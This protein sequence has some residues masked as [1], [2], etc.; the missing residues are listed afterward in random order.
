MASGPDPGGRSRFA[1]L[2]MA[3][4]EELNQACRDVLEMEVPPG[5]IYNKVKASSIYK[6]IRPE[7][8]LRL[9]GAKTD[10]YKEFDITLLYTLIRNISTKIPPPTKGW[11][12]N[13][14][15]PVGETTIGDD[16]ERIRMIRNS[17]FGHISSASTSQTEFDD[18]WQIITDVCQRLQTY[19]NKDYLSG[20]SNIQSQALEE[21]NEK[22]IIENL[23]A[24]YKNNTDLME[25]MSCL[26]SYLL[27]I[28]MI[29]E[30]LKVWQKENVAFIP[31]KA[32]R[33]VEEKLKSHNLVIVVGNSG[34]GKSAIIQHI[35][36]KY[37]D[38][39]SYVVP[40]DEVKEIK[41]KYSYSTENQTLFVLNDPLGKESLDEILFTLWKKYQKTIE[42]CLKKVKLLL[43]CRR[44]VLYDKRIK[45]ILFEESTIV[46][47]DNK[48]NGLTG[49]EKRAILNQYTQNLD[50][51]EEIVF[52]IIKTEAYFPLLCKL[53][54][55]PNYT[56]NGLDFFKF[57]KKFIKQ[58][59]D[60]FK[61][62]D[63][64]KFCTLILVVAF[65]NNLKIETIERN[66][67]SKKKYKDIL[68]MCE[69]SESTRISA[70]RS[71]L[72]EL[73]GSYVKCVGQTFQFLHDFIMEITTLVFGAECPKETI[74]YADSGFLRRRV[75]IV[76][77]TEEEN[78]D[79]FTVYLPEEYIGDLV[80]R[81]IVDMQ[82]E[83]IVDV[84]FNPC[85]RNKTGNDEEHLREA[86][87]ETKEGERRK[88]VSCLLN[89]GA[90]VNLCGDDGKPPLWIT[91]QKGYASTLVIMDMIARYNYY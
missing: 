2:G 54:S 26:E 24:H 52:E 17:M 32:S 25:R 57:P 65:K 18:T 1:K 67:E 74:Q 76:D 41:E 77:D 44:C 7:Q 68:E 47:I 49:V 10:G 14:M 85:L 61:R 55:R 23:E 62:I 60:I 72:Q 71:T 88:T 6:N 31:T 79:P 82:T 33:I 3:I 83:H 75:R 87:K 28:P 34:S 4:N 84:L 35:A 19:T 51:S 40:V 5:L 80:D 63:K 30:I 39:G 56:E 48:E 13:T 21:E 22:A 70:F 11:G 66:D 15:P 43:S 69:L 91:C 20:L 59:I 53:F 42:T 81:F 12:G 45:G 86:G 89:C 27:G 36:L 46:E 16:I 78:R 38:R 73:T 29:D 58:E 90:K 9:R 50:L 8:E 37:K 64:K